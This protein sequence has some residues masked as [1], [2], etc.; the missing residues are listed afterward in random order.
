LLFLKPWSI[1]E[2][3]ACA[4]PDITLA[5]VLVLSLMPYFPVQKLISYLLPTDQPLLV[6]THR[7][8]NRHGLLGPGT[9]TTTVQHFLPLQ[10]VYPDAP[11]ETGGS[12]GPEAAHMKTLSGS[13][14]LFPIVLS[15]RQDTF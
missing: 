13:Q 11:G 1:I 5:I 4:V 12:A 15:F 14:F 7:L 2:N 6:W 8:H 3:E 10:Y 9:L